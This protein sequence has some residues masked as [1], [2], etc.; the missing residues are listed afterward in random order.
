MPVTPNGKGQRRQPSANDSRLIL[1][2]AAWLNIQFTEQQKKPNPSY[3]FN[4]GGVCYTNS[5]DGD[6]R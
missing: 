6:E 1:G 3:K 4:P 2:K 5:I